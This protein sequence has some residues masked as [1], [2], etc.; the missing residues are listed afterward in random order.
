MAQ[1]SSDRPQAPS[2]HTHAFSR[3]AFAQATGALSAGAA[4]TSLAPRTTR[5][6]GATPEASPGAS[7]VATTAG[8]PQFG[9]ENQERGA[10]DELRLLVWQAPSV[11][12]PHSG[13]GEVDFVAAAPVLEPLLHFLPDG[14][15]IPNLVTDVPSM[16]NGLLAPDLSTATFTLL[17]DV[18]WSDGEPFTA[19]DVEFTWEWITTE[20]NASSNF[21]VWDTIAGI[22][23]P[24]D[25]TVVVTYKIPSLAWFEPFTGN[26]SGPIYPAHVFGDD[27]ASPNEAFLSNPIGTGPYVIESF[28]TDDQVTY[29]MNENYREQTKPYFQRVLLK[30]GGDP[31]SAARAVI[32]TGEF[33]FGWNIQIEPEVRQQIEADGEN[34]VIYSIPGVLVEQLTFNLS[35][36][37]TTVDGQRSQKDTPHPILSN[38]AVR[39]ALSLA[40]QRD[41]IAER[42]YGEGQPPAANILTG[43]PA[44]T[45]P[46]TSW[47]FDPERAGEILDEAGW[48]LDGD[49]RVKDGVELALTVAAATSSVRQKEQ[50]VVK[51]NWERIGVRVEIESIPPEVY[52][53]GS[54]GNDQNPQHKYRDADIAANGPTSP[55]PT[56]YLSQ[57]YAGPDGENI[58]QRENDWQRDNTLRWQNAEYDA[59]FESLL[60]ETDV[61][62]A[63]ETSIALNDL[64][65]ENAV[66]IPLVQRTDSPYALGNRIRPENVAIGPRFAISLW[67]IANWNEAEG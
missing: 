45:S 14:T 44:F 64:V 32:Q 49:V 62:R 13:S 8:R 48:V 4:L 55:I 31:A 3:R 50:A 40:V 52:F 15:I 30:G 54:P 35:D 19:R 42:F 63:Q 24:D 20:S 56:T 37:N 29:V 47:A 22:E 53:D 9:T 26:Y 5:A 23:T 25:L 51:E 21:S 36:P 60:Q 67:N 11:A 34:G 18:T 59:L 1:P 46:N 58:A 16:E 2:H 12:A 38:L 39:Q 6:Q 61:A 66:T 65:I 17:P 7:P 43:I 10:G 33:D 57:W 41:V 28:A 27:P